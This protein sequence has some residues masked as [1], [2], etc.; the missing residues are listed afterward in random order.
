MVTLMSLT[1]L[2]GKYNVFYLAGAT[3]GMGEKCN[4][5]TDTFTGNQSGTCL[6]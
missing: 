3:S 4:E 5:G 2:P 1:C 6:A